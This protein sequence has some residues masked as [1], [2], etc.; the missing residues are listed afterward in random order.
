[1]PFRISILITKS[2][3]AQYQWNNVVDNLVNWHPARSL[4][5]IISLKTIPPIEF[6]WFVRH[7]ISPVRY[8][9]TRHFSHLDKFKVKEKGERRGR[10]PATDEDIILPARRVVTFNCSA[11]LRGKVNGG[12]VRID[13]LTISYQYH[14]FLIPAEKILSFYPTPYSPVSSESTLISFLASDQ[15]NPHTIH[16]L[17]RDRPATTTWRYQIDKYS[18]PCEWNPSFRPGTP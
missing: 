8:Q 17:I 2:R 3:S 4:N 14:D 15:G 13:P 5:W 1:M 11:T 7:D 12:W 6:R 10:N 9:A 18:F 16:G